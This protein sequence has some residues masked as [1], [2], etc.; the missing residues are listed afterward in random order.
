MVKF[1]ITGPE[2]SGKTTLAKKLSETYNICLVEEYA[3]KYLN[4][5]ENKYGFNDLLKIAYKQYENEKNCKQFCIC[6]TD[7]ITIKIWSNYKYSKC[8][9][10]IEEKIL[11]HKDFPTVLAM[12]RIKGN[13]YPGAEKLSE[14]APHSDTQFSHMGAIYY[15]NTN[16]GWTKFKGGCKVKCVEN[17]M[18][19]FDSNIKHC[20]FTCTN[21][22]RKVVINFN[23]GTN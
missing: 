15:I 12:M 11:K 3:R 10:W 1:I 6:D 7:L 9:S 22:N 8:D 18:V 5:N 20:G 13:M 2:S 16:N 19:I 23:Y 14:H 4:E 21:E 17:R